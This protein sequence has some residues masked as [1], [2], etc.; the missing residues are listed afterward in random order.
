MSTVCLFFGLMRPEHEADHSSQFNAKVQNKWSC[1]CIPP[2]RNH[3]AQG[4]S[5]THCAYR[6]HQ[7]KPGR[8]GKQLYLISSHY[9]T[10]NCPGCIIY[11]IPLDRQLNTKNLDVSHYLIF[12]TPCFPVWKKF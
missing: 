7:M 3:G 9:T 5:Y 12:P 1:R 8:F 4:Q 10:A 11:F 6:H 2:V